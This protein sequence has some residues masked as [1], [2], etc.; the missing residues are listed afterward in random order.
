[1]NIEARYKQI[2]EEL[3]DIF[4][5]KINQY[6]IGMYEEQSE[7]FRYWGAYFN[8]RRKTLRLH[9]LTRRSLFANDALVIR[10]EARDK[11]I[12]DYKDI[13][14]YAIM[15]VQILEERDEIRSDSNT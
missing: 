2:Q 3:A 11:L 4:L 15:A 10:N 8:I 14:N 1:M 5:Q 12:D 7:Q 9:E 6:G 13:A